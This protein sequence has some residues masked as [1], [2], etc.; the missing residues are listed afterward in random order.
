MMGREGNQN[1][2]GRGSLL[3]VPS[4][5]VIKNLRFSAGEK[6]RKVIVGFGNKKCEVFFKEEGEK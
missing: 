2:Q 5:W 6:Q 4:W 3:D 1:F